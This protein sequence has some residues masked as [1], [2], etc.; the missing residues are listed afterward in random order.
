[1]IRVLIVDDSATMRSL[2]RRA[3]SRHPDIDVVGEAE[4]PL[5]AREAIKQ[6]DPDVLTL[7]IEMPHMNGLEFLEKIMRLRPMPVIVVSTLTRRGASETVEALALGAFDCVQKP[8]PGSGEDGFADLGERVRHAARASG[9]LL[10]A[11]RM[12]AAPAARPMS[13]GEA[14]TPREHVL[15]IGA[16]TGGVEALLAVFSEFPVDCPPTVVVQHMPAFFT[17]SFAERLNR[18]C[19]PAVCE[20]AHGMPLKPGTIY[21][22]PGG[23]R[24]LEIIDRDGLRCTLREGEKV[25]HHCPSVD[26]LF[27]SVARS[28]GQRAVGA[29][30]T[31]MG[32]D[33]AA[34]LKEMR[35]AGARTISQNE[36]TSIVYGMPRAAHELGASERQLP[37]NAIARALLNAGASSRGAAGLVRS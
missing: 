13:K 2:L 6:L 35:Q 29:L 19:A 30:L 14:S 15:A 34:G 33:G 21:I 11:R 27:S 31:G 18:H 17:N 3:L 10:S 5:V 1:M 28:C 26:V 4:H 36:A 22:A 9:K 20:A 7:D 24:H 16:S 25:N 12:V 23:V 37:L 32:A 8:S